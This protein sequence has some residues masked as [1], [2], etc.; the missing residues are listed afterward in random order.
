LLKDN[1]K[2]E[3]GKLRIAAPRDTFSWAREIT[4]WWYS[5]AALPVGS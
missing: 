3:A 1:F 4:A 2:S 5:G